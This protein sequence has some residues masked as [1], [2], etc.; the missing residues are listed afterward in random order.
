MQF[1]DSELF[2]ALQRSFSFY[3]MSPGALPLAITL[4]TFSAPLTEK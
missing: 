1:S 4:R 2:R 3:Y